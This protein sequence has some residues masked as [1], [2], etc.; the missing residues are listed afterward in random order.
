MLSEP[1][2]RPPLL[3]LLLVALAGAVAYWGTVVAPERPPVVEPIEAAVSSA[4][5]AEL[6]AEGHGRE[7]EGPVALV[8]DELAGAFRDAGNAEGAEG[9][10]AAPRRFT[11]LPSS[12]P[13]AGYSLGAVTA[14]TAF[15]T[16][17]A[18]EDPRAAR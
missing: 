15:V 8:A 4:A 2:S 6:V 3:A 7:C 10:E 5:G 9:V 16:V 14:P 12:S 18:G 13:C 1:G 11:P 17:R